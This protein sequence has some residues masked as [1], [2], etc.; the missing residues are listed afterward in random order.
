MG[1]LDHDITVQVAELT[2]MLRERRA[3]RWTLLER[4]MAKGPQ[5]M[6]DLDYLHDFDL[7]R[8]LTAD[9]PTLDDD[10]SLDPAM[11]KP[12]PKRDPDAL[13][14]AAQAAARLAITVEQLISHVEDGA[15]RYI[16]VGRGKKRPRYRFDPADLDAFKAAR[17]TLEN[18]H[19]PSSSRKNPRPTT[20]TASKSNVVGFSALRAAQL[21]RKPRRLKP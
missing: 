3:G 18:A 11:P 21:A 19:C 1:A 6:R 10:A 8:R 5:V 16:N 14:T 17:S 15:L 9:V 13:F 2:Q 7:T 20:G 12:K 4:L